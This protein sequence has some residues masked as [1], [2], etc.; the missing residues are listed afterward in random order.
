MRMLDIFCGRFGWSRAF[1][2]RGW[3][4][5][6]V[7]LVA[8]PE[9]PAGCEFLQMDALTLT[10]DFLRQFDFICASSPCEE[11]SVHGMKHFHPKPEVS[12]ERHTAVQPHAGDLR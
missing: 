10:A 8:P 3:H 4:C 11:F 12:R 7:D 2:A 5:T 1:A 9:V 6:G